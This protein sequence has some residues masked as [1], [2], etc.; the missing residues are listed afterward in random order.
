MFSLERF[1]FQESILS[2]IKTLYTNIKGCINNN[3]WILEPYTIER[4]IRQQYPLS[5]LIFITV[6]EIIIKFIKSINY[7]LF[8]VIVF[9]Y[10]FVG[11]LICHDRN[12]LL[13][14]LAVSFVQVIF[15]T[16]RRW[17]LRTWRKIHWSDESRFLLHET[18]GRMRVWK[19]K[20]TAYTPRNIQP[21]VPSLQ[22]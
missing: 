12:E 10:Y 5:A 18:D 21:T 8:F 17:N 3:V 9:Q 20:T 6:G 7:L 2:W 16:R 4:G 11:I 15:S 13:N 14:I 1:G 22:S 19:H